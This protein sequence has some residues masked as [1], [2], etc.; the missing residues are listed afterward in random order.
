MLINC[1]SSKQKTSALQKTVK[2]VKRQATEWEKIF[3]NHTSNKRLAFRIC[4]ELLILNSDTKNNPLFHC[5]FCL[6]TKSC[7]SVHGISQARI[8][9]WVAIS[10]FTGSSQPR[11][12]THISCIGRQILYRWATREAQ[13]TKREHGKHPYTEI[14]VKKIHRWQVGLWKGLNVSSYWGHVNWNHNELLLAS[15]R[16]AKL[17]KIVTTLSASEDAGKLDHSCNAG[18]RVKW[19]N[20]SEKQFIASWK[21]ERA[22]TVWPSS[23]TTR[24]L[25]QKMKICVHTQK[26]PCT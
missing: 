20:H 3:S 9:E 17:K 13:P 25:T 24:C 16:R 19:S 15:I 6:V 1:T 7:L 11:D 21:S 2:K 8:L 18:G 4:Q 5:C 10:F 26:K 22:T 12:Q 14:S 23:Y